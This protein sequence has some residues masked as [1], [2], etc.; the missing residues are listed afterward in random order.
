MAFSNKHVST[1]NTNISII[2]LTG[3]FDIDNDL[4][5]QELVLDDKFTNDRCTNPYRRNNKRNT[6]ATR[7]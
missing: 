3:E 6:L 4:S 5:H 2:T 1:L 7:E